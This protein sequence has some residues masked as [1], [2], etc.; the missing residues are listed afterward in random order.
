MS[1]MKKHDPF[2]IPEGVLSHITEHSSG[3]FVLFTFDEE[4]FPKIDMQFDDAA[5]AKAMQGYIKDWIN[6]M[7]HINTQLMISNILPE[8]PKRKRGK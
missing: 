4:G 3:G 2:Q 1:D 5:R 8:P 7:D 6:A